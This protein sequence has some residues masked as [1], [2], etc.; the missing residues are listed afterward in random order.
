MKGWALFVS[1]MIGFARAA[2]FPSL[3]SIYARYAADNPANVTVAP[4]KEEFSPAEVEI[5]SGTLKLP[6]LGFGVIAYPKGL[7]FA[8]PVYFASSGVLPSPLRPAT[9]Y[10]LVP[11]KEGGYRVFAAAEDKDAELQPGGVPGEKVLPGQNA[12][13]G[14]GA[15]VFRDGGTGTHTVTTKPLLSQLTD[16]SPNGLQ[17]QARRPTDK[18][19]LLELV[20]DERGKP[21]VRT[22]GGLMREN[23]VGSYSAYGPSWVQGPGGKR[24]EARQKVGGQRVVY[25]IFVCRVRS[26]KERQVVK[27]LAKPENIDAATGRISYAMD[28]RM[29]NRVNTGDLILVRTYGGGKLPSPLKEGTDYFA[30]KVDGKTLTLHT[31]A[32][33]ARNNANALAL[34]DAGSGEFLFWLPERVGDGRRWSF[35][36]ETLAPDSGGNTL[37]VRLQEPITQG[38]GL[39]KNAADFT[40]TGAGNGNV[41]GLATVP[42]FTP[43][44]FWTPPRAALPAPL[45]A[46]TRYWISKAPGSA[47]TARLHATLESAKS[48]AGKATAESGCILFTAPG[49]GESLASYDDDASGIAYGTLSKSLEPFAKRLPLGPLCVL[50]FKI[51]FNDPERSSVYATFGLNEAMTEGKLLNAQKGMTPAAI[52][53][54][55]P[56]WTMFNSAQGHVPIDLDL[57]EVVFGSS[58]E[59]VPDSEIQ[60][61]VDHF[62]KKYEIP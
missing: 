42:E 6:D 16:L 43:V 9:P 32:D 40:V 15:V 14:V 31:T 4:V 46:G 12:A 51:D 61:V 34:T 3:P 56:A 5:A 57:Y 33:D 35:F 25:Q 19:S 49:K 2:D 62:K 8:T 30:R 18:H 38:G 10:Y 28:H 29:G 54:P 44:I 59:A 11:A 26:Y 36:A 48:G 53:E 41:K 55:F 52:Q 50:V 27:F 60:T 45:Q 22:V 24:A 17:S 58:T 13:Q 20:T 21:F 39:L 23:W 37:S 7:G 47:G 1:L